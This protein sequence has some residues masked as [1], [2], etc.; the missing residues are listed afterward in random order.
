MVIEI[1]LFSHKKSVNFVAT[2]LKNTEK[3][4]AHTYTHVCH[5]E[6]IFTRLSYI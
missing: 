5:L 4:H 6:N 1:W 3:K 2:K